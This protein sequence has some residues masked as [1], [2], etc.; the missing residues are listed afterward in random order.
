MINMIEWGHKGD[1][2]ILSCLYSLYVPPALL[3][4]VIVIQS[5]QNN[6]MTL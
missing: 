1:Y 3:N 5:N 6:A 4:G 2:E